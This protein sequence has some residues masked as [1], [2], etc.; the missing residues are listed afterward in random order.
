MQVANEETVREEMAANV[1]RQLDLG[2][3]CLQLWLQLDKDT[4]LNR[5][6]LPSEV[7][8]V[9]FA[10][11][12]KICRQLR[13]VIDLCRR[14]EAADAEIIARSMYEAVLATGFVL[15]PRLILREFRNDG[16]VKRT[17]REPGKPL[18]RQ[19]RARLYLAHAQ[20]FAERFKTRHAG[21]PGKK[22]MATAV[23]KNADPRT[24]NRYRTLIGSGW[25][26]RLCTHPY[27]YSGL[28]IANLARSFGARIGRAFA[29]WHDAVY[30]FQ[31][32]HVHA[33]DVVEFIETDEDGNFRAK[34][35]SECAHVRRALE[36]GIAMFLADIGLLND[37]IPFDVVMNTAIRSLCSE[38]QVLIKQ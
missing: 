20:L 8:R 15:V 25:T 32:E 26:K 4:A 19:L 28:S 9:A 11:N 12:V 14:G 21:K 10:M 36:A 34:W 1:G 7:I 27:T 16:T 6:R 31:S 17:I 38:Y 3:R 30:P 37:H 22:R 24:I 35:N 33:V 2:R 23:A 18:S 5:S 29:N 13:T